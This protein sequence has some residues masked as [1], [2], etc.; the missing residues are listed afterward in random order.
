MRSKDRIN[1]HRLTVSQRSYW[2]TRG[3]YEHDDV[4][5]DAHPAMCE[6]ST[7]CLTPR[8]PLD[9]PLSRQTM[10]DAD[11]TDTSMTPKILNGVKMGEGD[12]T[13]SLLSLGA[14]CVEGWKR[15]RWNP[16][17]M[18]VV[19]VEVGLFTWRNN[20]GAPF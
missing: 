8:A 6:N 20:C 4:H 7:E 14:M 19:T 17:G 13:V 12:G 5:A 16:S 3:A 11:Y 18:Q 10:I 9:M 1:T 15:E 2:Y